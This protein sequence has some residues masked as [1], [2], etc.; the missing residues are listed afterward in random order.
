M[1]PNDPG[2]PAPHEPERSDSPPSPLTTGFLSA[3]SASL[4]GNGDPG[5]EDL[6]SLLAGWGVADLPAPTAPALMA[7]ASMTPAVPQVAASGSVPVLVT[8][9]PVDDSPTAGLSAVTINVAEAAAG[10]AVVRAGETRKVDALI[11]KPVSAKELG[12]TVGDTPL[13]GGESTTDT[14]PAA[15]RAA[16]GPVGPGAVRSV[17]DEAAE[18]SRRARGS[19]AGRGAGGDAPDRYTTA[20]ATTPLTVR[21]AKL[22]GVVVLM[23]VAALTGWG[24]SEPGPV[25]RGTLRLDGVNDPTPFLT[26]TGIRQLAVSRLKELAPDVSPG[27]LASEAALGEWAGRAV[28]QSGVLLMEVPVSTGPREL[29]NQQLRLRALLTA[30]AE[31]ATPVQATSPAQMALLRDTARGAEEAL[32]AA[33]KVQAD[34]EAR[35]KD[36]PRLVQLVAEIADIQTRR[37][38]L[39]AR[40]AAAREQ[41]PPTVDEEAR[42]RLDAAVAA[43]QKQLDAVKAVQGTDSRLAPFLA[44][45]Q[46]VQDEGQRLTE[47]MFSRRAD[48]GQRLMQLKKR[49]DDRLRLRQQQAWDAD[50]ELKRLG[51]QLAD[52]RKRFEATDPGNISRRQDLQGEI[53]YLDGL[54]KARKVYVGVDKGDQRAVAEIQQIIDDQARATEQDRQQMAQRFAQMQQLLA[55]A[56]P[57]AGAMTEGQGAIARDLEA[58][59]AELQQARTALAQA[60]AT[61]IARHEQTLREL[62]TQLADADRQLLEKQTAAEQVRAG[63]PNTRQLDDA[64]TRTAL[65]SQNLEAAQ[66][67]VTDAEAGPP[68]R[69]IPIPTVQTGLAEAH[70]R[71]FWVVIPAALTGIVAWALLKPHE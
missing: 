69:A 10:V 52:A 31:R 42:A 3:S 9:A 59:L 39:A 58:R 54:I 15:S 28:G 33:R 26:A 17:R 56:L 20:V 24:F 70:G 49:L 45:V 57:E 55:R 60:S 50:D 66:K 4:S 64:A 46:N 65:F 7:P 67:A 43:F 48:E 47:Q 32:A 35:A 38:G 22:A 25:V 41:P 34:L 44:A 18:L 11:E 27:D 8:S 51:E 63:L 30:V 68:P 62:D 13:R 36:S 12:G 14:D 6:D 19:V 40:L 61:L 29:E 5:G 21:L 2:Q 71:L 16:L 1:S 23:G 53:D 37:D